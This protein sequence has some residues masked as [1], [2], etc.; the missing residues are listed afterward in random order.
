MIRK[1]LFMIAMIFKN[2]TQNA[3]SR[4]LTKGRETK[5]SFRYDIKIDTKKNIL[6][7]Q[8]K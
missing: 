8:K 4:R 2:L 6:K 5:T 7:P 3:T 1:F